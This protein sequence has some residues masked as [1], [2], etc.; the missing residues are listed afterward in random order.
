MTPKKKKPEK[1]RPIE[2]RQDRDLRHVHS[3]FTN[4]RAPSLKVGFLDNSFNHEVAPRPA[5]ASKM[6]V[7]AS[8]QFIAKDEKNKFEKPYTLEYATTDGVPASN[9]ELETV[10]N[11]IIHDVRPIKNKLSLDHEGFTFVDFESQMAYEDY[12]HEEKLRSLFAQEL[13]ACL[14]KL[15]GASKIF[16]HECLVS[17]SNCLCDPGIVQPVKIPNITWVSIGPKTC[18]RFSSL[19]CSLRL[20]SA[21]SIRTRW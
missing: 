16:F 9:F 20:R 12:F 11:I 18:P 21:S 17:R 4:I 6:N 8:L 5:N 3:T 15:L 1:E 14:K 13:R 7:R 19:C 2:R 10:D